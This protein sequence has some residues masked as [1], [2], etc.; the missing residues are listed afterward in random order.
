ME[1][2]HIISIQVGLPKW[3]RS[4]EPEKLWL[5]GIFKEPVKEPVWL[6]KTNLSG[7]GQANLEVHGGPDKAVLAYAACHYPFWSKELG[8]DLSHGAFGENFTID[9]LNE[10][11]ICI[12]DIY[13]VGEA[14][15]QITQPRQPCW[16][17]S[18]R[19]GIKDLVARVH[20][21]G[22]TGWYFRVLKEGYVEKGLPINLIERPFPEW[23]I[24]SAYEVRFSPTAGLNSILSLANCPL[25]S[26][27]WQ[28]ALF[29]KAQSIKS[30]G[31]INKGG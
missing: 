17:L 16:K 24:S 2:A 12:G 20:I 22:R 28:T 25:L 30:G 23:T 5:S 10:K 29:N 27:R 3:I 13:A 18:R 1:K 19:L 9:G 31:K 11:K 26:Q 21:S 15:V 14:V 4:G 8:L 7:D 6:G